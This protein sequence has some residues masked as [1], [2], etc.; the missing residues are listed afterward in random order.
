[1][2]NCDNV[3]A[4]ISSPKGDSQVKGTQEKSPTNKDSSGGDELPEDAVVTDVHGECLVIC[5]K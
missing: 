1:M 4:D 5:D 3:V 2:S